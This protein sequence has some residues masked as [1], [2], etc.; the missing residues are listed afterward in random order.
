MNLA[1]S[2][3]IN[4]LWGNLIIEELIRNGVEYFCLAPGSRSSPLAIAVALHPK[5][6]TFMHFDERGTAFHALGYTSASQRPCALVC[7]SGSAVANFFPAVVE[8]AKKKVPLIILTADR[9]PE[10]RLTGAD[11]TIDQVN[12]FG[13]YARWC[14]DLPCPTVE[15]KPEFVLTTIDQA[16]YRAKSSVAG[17]VHLNC[18]YREPLAPLSTGQNFENYLSGL[19][20]WQKSQ[21]PFTTCAN[22]NQ[23][24][25]P[26][27]IDSVT[28]VLAQIKKGVIVVGKL[29]GESEA[30]AVLKLAE[31]LHWPVFPDISS[32]LRLGIKHPNV[33]PYFD[34]ILLSDEFMASMPFDGVLHLGGRITAK[35]WYQFMEKSKPRHYVMV[36]NHPLRNDPLHNVTLRIESSVQNF[37]EKLTA[38]ISPANGKQNFRTLQQASESIDVNI[39]KFLSRTNVLT[40]IDVARTISESIPAG[41]GLFL[42]SSMPI[43]DM[44]MY[45]ASAQ[46]S[47]VVGANRGASGI[48]GTIASA[49]GFATGLNK[50]M[51]VVLG[52]L[53]FLHDLNSLAML[54]QMTQP[55]T[56][57]VINNN[58]SGIFSFLPIAQFKDVFEPY[59]GTPHGLTFSAAAELFDLEYHNPSSSEEFVKFYK[60]SL[61]AKKSTII[62]V[63]TERTENYKIH[64]DL[65]QRLQVLLDK[66]FRGGSHHDKNFG[67]IDESKKDK[68]GRRLDTL[69]PV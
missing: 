3:N 67:K 53:A 27:T 49:A 29:S 7:T 45:A 21:S 32:G 60:K 23:L 33:I 58:G 18:M 47:V 2:P 59:F 40:E 11:Q 8:A 38:S 26:D 37:C 16:V 63:R 52:D 64:Q 4:Q 17:P 43:R 41:H 31:K 44:D 62:E 57:V 6:K 36:L 61:T 55:L 69:R 66:H 20:Q 5:A 54:R 42:A 48:D 68:I 19:N 10:L 46:N 13:N 56:L 14:V 25:S 30:Q 12:I 35:R 50:P 22:T 51:T 28:A 9:P 15:I 65:Q 24:L 39:K 34:Q 1:Q